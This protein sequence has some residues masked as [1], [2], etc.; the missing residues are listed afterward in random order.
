MIFIGYYFKY[1]KRKISECNTLISELENKYTLD[2]LFFFNKK[3]IREFYEYAS[4][5]PS[6]CPDQYGVFR[7]EDLK[8]LDKSNIFLGNIYG[9][10]TLSL[11][12][13]ES[14]ADLEELKIVTNQYYLLL[15]SGLYQILGFIK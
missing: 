13:F 12:E 3:I 11:K 6:I 15:K 4:K 7:V 9:L 10:W 2:D 14:K 8:D 5:S 1:K